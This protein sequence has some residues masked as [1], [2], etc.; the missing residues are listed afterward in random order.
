[1][2]SRPSM[3]AARV[4]ITVLLSGAAWAY[5]SPPSAAPPAN[6]GADASSLAAWSIHTPESVDW[7][8]RSSAPTEWHV[9]I[10][11]GRVMVDTESP[12]E[13]T[14]L[15]FKIEP[16]P[17][18]HETDLAGPQSVFPV[19][20][21]YLVGFDAGEF[22]GGVWWFSA[23]GGRRRKLTLRAS[24]S[25][26]DY[27]S[28]NVHGFAR[29]GR[30]VL[31]LEGLT[32][33]SG[34][35]GRVVRIHRGPDGEWRPSMFAKLS[36]CPH[37]VIQ[38]SKSSWFLATTLGIWRIDAQGRERPVWQPPGGHLYY[39]N[40]IVRDGSGVVYMGMRNHIVRM[41]PREKGNYT[42]EVL[43]PPTP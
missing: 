33:L 24:D 32:H 36:A 6:S 21:G 16:L 19:D 9:W 37:A 26:E 35:S 25:I 28:E 11:N 27:I 15:P 23:D 1:M 29:L 17:K 39:P 43:D 22:G 8:A 31:V 38:E 14:V 18:E 10:E 7:D 20:G 41:T 4:A 34:N 30:D 12:A 40:S 5:G 2:R 13:A 3:S 42:L